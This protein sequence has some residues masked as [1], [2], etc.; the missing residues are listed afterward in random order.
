MLGPKLK[1]R[2]L[3]AVMARVGIIGVAIVSS[4]YCESYP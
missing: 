4:T 3:G 1:L 2:L